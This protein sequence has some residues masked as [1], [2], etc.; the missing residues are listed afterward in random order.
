MDWGIIRRFRRPGD[1]KDLYASIED[2]HQVFARVIRERKRR[3]IDPTVDAIREC[4][5][6]MPEEAEGRERLKILLRIFTVI[7]LAYQQAFASDEAFRE[8]VDLFSGRADAETG[9]AGA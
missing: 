1:R 4:L 7:D 2:V 6:Q 3:E 8:M 9:P 5:G